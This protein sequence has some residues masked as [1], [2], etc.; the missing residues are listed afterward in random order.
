MSLRQRTKR[1]LYGFSPS[2]TLIVVLVGFWVRWGISES[3]LIIMNAYSSTCE[4]SAAMIVRWVYWEVG[5]KSI[6]IG[7]V[8]ENELCAMCRNEITTA[9]LQWS[10]ILLYSSATKKYNSSWDRVT[11]WKKMTKKMII[12]KWDQIQRCC[13]V[14]SII[15]LSQ[16]MKT[17]M[18]L[19]RVICLTTIWDIQGDE[20]ETTEHD[21][22][23]S[24]QRLD[25]IS[26]IEVEHGRLCISFSVCSASLQ[27]MHVIAGDCARALKF[28]HS[29][30]IDFDKYN[31]SLAMFSDRSYYRT[32]VVPPK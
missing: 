14:L 22:G 32:M 27:S 29:L 25:Y 8:Q 16:L 7:D 26:S 3:T 4:R 1:N 19:N 17:R 10:D 23:S 11:K 13:R 9:E 6:W 5:W 20:N 12:Q 31:S 28:R 15:E 2:M 18:V 21:V 24:S 30:Y